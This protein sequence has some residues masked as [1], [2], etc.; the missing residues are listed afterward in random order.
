VAVRP[1]GARVGVH[2]RRR[3]HGG[4]RVR[5]ARARR[6]AVAPGRLRL[7]RAPRRGLFRHRHHHARDGERSLQ[8]SALRRHRR[9]RPHGR[10]GRERARAVACGMAL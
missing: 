8:R 9:H 10:G 3:H 7:R 2:G 5:A 1:H 4:E 6:G